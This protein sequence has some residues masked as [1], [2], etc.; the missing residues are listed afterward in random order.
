MLNST[1]ATKSPVASYPYPSIRN[2]YVI[3][4]TIAS[5]A[6]L[7]RH[8]SAADFVFSTVRRIRAPTSSKVV[9]VCAWE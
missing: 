3:V 5:P 7:I 9:S 1:R 8:T 2:T 6:F 4:L